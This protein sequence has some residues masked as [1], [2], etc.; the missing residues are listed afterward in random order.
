M[1]SD[2]LKK[3]PRMAEITL[4]TNFI[5]WKSKQLNLP[6]NVRLQNQG[7]SAGQREWPLLVD[8]PHYLIIRSDET[9]PRH[10]GTKFFSIKTA[11]SSFYFFF[12]VS[13]QFL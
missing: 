12:V 6:S 11:F 4:P 13:I 1:Q 9:K 10:L 8:E 2:F 7:N 3:V 5:D